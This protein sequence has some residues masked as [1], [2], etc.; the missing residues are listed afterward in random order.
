MHISLE[1]ALHHILDILFPPQCV[2]CKRD[3]QILC[4]SC[5]TTIQPLTTP[6][7]NYCQTPLTPNGVCRCQYYPR[8]LSG[9]RVFG[10]YHGSLR[11]CIHALKY[12]GNTRLAQPL[13]TLLAQ[14]YNM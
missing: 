1:R 8:R 2:V 11:S 12:N 4:T 14:A 13:G 10:S 3:G 7:C 6:F 9:L 5:L